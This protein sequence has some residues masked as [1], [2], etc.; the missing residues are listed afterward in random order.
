MSLARGQSPLPLRPGL[1]IW[2]RASYSCPATGVWGNGSFGCLALRCPP[3]P[4]SF[5]GAPPQHMP[6]LKC[7]DTGHGASLAMHEASE[8]GL[9]EFGWRL[10]VLHGA[11]GALVASRTPRKELTVGVATRRA[12]PVVRRRRNANTNGRL[13]PPDFS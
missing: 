10:R 12:A 4:F 5:V 7:I 13:S 6:I 9:L 1:L 8:R 2:D 3:S 11:S